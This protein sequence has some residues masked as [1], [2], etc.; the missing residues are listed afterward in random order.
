[1][2]VGIIRDSDHDRAID[3]I[4]HAISEPLLLTPQQCTPPSIHQGASAFNLFLPVAATAGKSDSAACLATQCRA[5]RQ[6]GYSESRA[7]ACTE[8]N[9]RSTFLGTTRS[10]YTPRPSGCVSALQHGHILYRDLSQHNNA[11]LRVSHRLLV[12]V[13][14]S[15]SSCN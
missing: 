9:T 7:E 11:I 15:F 5:W 1:M 3:I 2:R 4:Q 13:T 14:R 8:E 6:R 12:V 10:G